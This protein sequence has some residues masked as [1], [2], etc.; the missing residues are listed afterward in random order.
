MGN[1]PNQWYKTSVQYHNLKSGTATTGAGA[2]GGAIAAGA[3]A[4]GEG[5]PGDASFAEVVAK[6]SFETAGGAA[7]GGADSSSGAMAL[8]A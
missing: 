8:D 5:A 6:G 7:A 2:G 3:A 1:H 4:A